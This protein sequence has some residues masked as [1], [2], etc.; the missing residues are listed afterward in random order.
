[1][2]KL[3]S[4]S[5]LITQIFTCLKY[6]FSRLNMSKSTVGLTLRGGSQAFVQINRVF[7]VGFFMFFP[8][9][10]HPVFF[11][12]FHTFPKAEEKNQKF[13]QICFLQIQNYFIFLSLYLY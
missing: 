9:F 12:D 13:V 10:F 1:M 7:L 11:R 6:S 5:I 8:E 2:L 3:D 4:I